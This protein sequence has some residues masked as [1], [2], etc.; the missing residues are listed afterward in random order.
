MRLFTEILDKEALV[1]G[2]LEDVVNQY[3]AIRFRR[4]N[5]NR[6]GLLKCEKVMILRADI[7]PRI[8]SFKRR[9]LNSGV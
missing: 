9:G 2:P 4:Y 1:P 7:E 3:C 6:E 5:H 8:D